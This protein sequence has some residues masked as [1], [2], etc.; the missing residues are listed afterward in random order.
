MT[1]ASGEKFFGPFSGQFPE[2]LRLVFFHFKSRDDEET[3]EGRRMRADVDPLNLMLLKDAVPFFAYTPGGKNGAGGDLAGLH[4]SS[5]LMLSHW[6]NARR[7]SA[8]NARCLSRTRPSPATLE[9][10]EYMWEI[11]LRPFGCKRI[12]LNPA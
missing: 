4:P 6:R 10:K 5:R 7:K 3:S 11:L 9:P 2:R 8:W 12:P 1:F